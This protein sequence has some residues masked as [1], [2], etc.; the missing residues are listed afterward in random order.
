MEA[1]GEKHL[2]M[3]EVG[4]QQLLE[5][6]GLPQAAGQQAG[7]WSFLE[8]G[9]RRPLVRILPRQ[10]AEVPNEGENPLLVLGRDRVI[11]R[12]LVD[13]LGEEFRDESAR[14]VDGLS[15]RYR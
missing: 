1:L 12:I 7:T 13:S 5:A 4:F 2:V 15:V 11:Q 8:A 14:I 9:A 3:P 6:E 10:C